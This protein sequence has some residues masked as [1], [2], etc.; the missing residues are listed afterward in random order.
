MFCGKGRN[1]TSSGSNNLRAGLVEVCGWARVNCEVS[2]LLRA[3]PTTVSNFGD[4]PLVTCGHFRGCCWTCA[5]F[6]GFTSRPAR[7]SHVPMAVLTTGRTVQTNS[8]M[9]IWTK[10]HWV[11]DSAVNFVS[12]GVHAELTKNQRLTFGLRNRC[13]AGFAH[14]RAV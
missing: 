10:L 4:S 8:G 2:R 1:H 7:C 11:C 3:A 6:A 9:D 12:R 5:P 14:V 13:F